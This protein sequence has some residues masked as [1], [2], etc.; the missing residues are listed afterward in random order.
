[1]WYTAD[2]QS[3]RHE[4]TRGLSEE[5]EEM[6]Q[7]DQHIDWDTVKSDL[8]GAWRQIPKPFR[9]DRTIH[10]T[11]QC[12][13]FGRL[14]DCGYRVVADYLPPRIQERAVELIALNDD[15][16]IVHAICLDTVITLPAV[17]SLMSF[18]AVNRIILTTGALEKKV[19]ESRFF[20]KPEIRHVHLLPVERA[21]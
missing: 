2:A 3:R 8:E 5:E 21:R 16:Q 17:K 18:D 13:L 10:G 20:L 6:T 9:G 14:S 7:D 4:N 11:L 19:Q 12:R 1:V 15:L